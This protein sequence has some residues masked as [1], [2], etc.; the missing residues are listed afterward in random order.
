MSPVSAF[1]SGRK[2]HKQER[3]V[4][5]LW[6]ENGIRVAIWGIENQTTVDSS[7]PLRVIA[8]DGMAYKK[9]LIDNKKSKKKNKSEIK[10]IFNVFKDEDLRIYEGLLG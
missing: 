3:D 9:Q 5:K 8:Y 4:A 6:K 7:M 10:V 1:K 2:Y